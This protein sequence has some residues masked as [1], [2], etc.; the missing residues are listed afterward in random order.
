MSDEQEK[1]TA[2]GVCKEEAGSA[3]K[4]ALGE[5]VSES[6]AQQLLAEIRGLREDQRLA[7]AVMAHSLRQVVKAVKC[8]A[9][10][11]IG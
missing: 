7:N 2:P 10:I 9:A 3:T 5:P 4:L 6:T 1:A 11:V 8:D